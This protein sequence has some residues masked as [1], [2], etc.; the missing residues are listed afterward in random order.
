MSSRELFLKSLSVSF[1]GTQRSGTASLTK[2]LSSH[3]KLHIQ[4]ELPF[5]S[6]FTFIAKKFSVIYNLDKL[7]Q[8]NSLNR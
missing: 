4:N 8:K 3:P 7:Y 5:Q 1:L 6:I 2:I